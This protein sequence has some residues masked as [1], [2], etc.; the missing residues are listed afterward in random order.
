ML[1]F[2]PTFTRFSYAIIFANEDLIDRTLSIDHREYLLAFDTFAV[3][4]FVG[5]AT[6]SLFIHSHIT[7]R[8]TT[9][10]YGQSCTR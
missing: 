10:E 4:L 9:I 3:Q 2:P 7:D 5:S 1:D 8:K 6:Y